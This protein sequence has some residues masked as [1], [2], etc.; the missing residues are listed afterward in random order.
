M[1]RSVITMSPKS[2]WFQVDADIGELCHTAHSLED[3]GAVFCR[4]NPPY[5]HRC[6][7]SEIRLVQDVSEPVFEV[8]PLSSKIDHNPVD[9]AEH[10]AGFGI[11]FPAEKQYRECLSDYLTVRSAHEVYHAT[12]GGNVESVSVDLVPDLWWKSEER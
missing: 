1:V 12:R 4:R 2:R 9:V 8:N 11:C 6:D 7:R 10:V 3:N 5:R